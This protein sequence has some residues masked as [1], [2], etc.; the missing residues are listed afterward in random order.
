MVWLEMQGGRGGHFKKSQY[1]RE[2]LIISNVTLYLR[3][4]YLILLVTLTIRL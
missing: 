4:W 1:S 2:T 3:H